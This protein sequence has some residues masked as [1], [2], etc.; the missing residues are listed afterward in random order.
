MGKSFL[1]RNDYDCHNIK[2]SSENPQKSKMWVPK[3]I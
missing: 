3:N 2:E 1:L